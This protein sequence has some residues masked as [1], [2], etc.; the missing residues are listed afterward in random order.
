MSQELTAGA[1]EDSD[2]MS[3]YRKEACKVVTFRIVYDREPGSNGYDVVTFAPEM[4]HQVFGESESIFGYKQIAITI[5]MLHNSCRCFL[6]VMFSGAIQRLY[7]KPDDVKKALNPW[8]PANYTNDPSEFERLVDSE[9]H[10]KMFGEVISSYSVPSARF[11]QQNVQS[12]IIITKTDTSSAELRDFHARFE[13]YIVWFIDAANFI[14]LEDDRWLIFYAYEEFQHPISKKTYKT[15]IA[16]CSVY[17]F[18]SFPSNVRARISQFFVLPSHQRRGIGTALYRTVVETL[19]DMKEVVD[20][21]VEEPTSAFQRIR[22]LEDSLIVHQALQEKRVNYLKV[23]ASAVLELGKGKKIGK[24]QMQRVYDILGLYYADR[25][26]PACSE[27]ILSS[28]RNRVTQQNMRELRPGKRF[29]RLDGSATP[30]QTTKKDEIENDL[31]RYCDD[32][33]SSADHLKEKMPTR[34]KRKR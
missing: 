13:T 18:F 1:Q 15:P 19:K 23:E 22:D 6:S 3:Y 32:I 24:K 16:Y 20:F 28:I 8:L 21:T 4:A 7:S 2:A 5:D 30:V 11:S 12:K 27:K 31:K 34:S 25:T 26:G 9:D 17:K 10:E 33:Q 14:D 29:C